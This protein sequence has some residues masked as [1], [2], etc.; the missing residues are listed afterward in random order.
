[1]NPTQFNTAPSQ[2]TDFDLEYNEATTDTVKVALEGDD[3]PEK[4]RGKSAKELAE[5]HM[6]AE[7][8]LSQTGNEL[9]QLRKLADQLLELK[10]DNAPERKVEPPKPL[11]VDEIFA[12]PDNAIKRAVESSS[13]HKK[14]EEASAKAESIE[15]AL[16]IQSFQSKYPTYQQDLSDPVF[17]DWVG[18]NSARSE[19]FRRAD[20]YD[21]ASAD[22]LWQMWG[23]YKELKSITEKRE[24]AKEKRQEAL[25][26][27]KTVSEAPLDSSAKGPVYSRA[28]L[29]ELQSRAHGGDLSARAK[30]NDPAFQTEL[31]KAYAEQRVR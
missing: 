13:A 27:G 5:M 25:K 7:K 18:A 19:L 28:K 20:N 14:A 23:E 24:A 12:D 3:L 4:Y 2:Q 6:N 26:A 21:V 15:R 16:A 17:Q 29:M 10:K 31:L 11:T 8:R 9:G 30:W 22:A 1:M